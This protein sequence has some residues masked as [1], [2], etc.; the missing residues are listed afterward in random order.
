MF[1]FV[2]RQIVNNN[3]IIKTR[4]KETIIRSRTF[5]AC[6][7]N[8][9]GITDHKI[10]REMMPEFEKKKLKKNEELTMRT[11]RV[12]RGVTWDP[13]VT[14]RVCPSGFIFSFTLSLQPDLFCDRCTL[15]DAFSYLY[16]SVYWLICSFITPIVFHSFIHLLDRILR[17]FLYME[18]LSLV[19]LFGRDV[20]P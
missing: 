8:A 18:W 14:V 5:W 10:A 1:A 17:P 9:I 15:P 16:F 13:D 19:A 3:K 11:M 2:T 20:A 12:S 4:R 7:H 6:L